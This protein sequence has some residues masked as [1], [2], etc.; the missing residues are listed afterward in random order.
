VLH[1]LNGD[2][3]A[4]TFRQSGLP[5]EQLVWKEA[6]IWGPTPAEPNVSQ[7][8]RLRADFLAGSNGMDAERCFEN[9]MQQESAVATLESHEEVVLW[10][11][12]DLFCQLNLIYVLGKLRSCNLAGT[13]LSLI[14]IGDFPGIEDFRGLG[15]LTAEQLASL[16]PFREPV[17]AEQTD[18]A[19]TAWHACSSSNPRDTELLLSQDTTTLPFL[20][21]ALQLHLRRFPS[22]KNGLGRIEQTA[23]ECI[24]GGAARFPQLF[25]TWSRPQAGYGLGDTQFWDS[26]IRLVQCGRPL[27]RLDG[28]EGLV[29]P[30]NTAAQAEFTLTETGRSVLT[31]KSDLWDM[32][33]QELWLG[34][35][36]LAPP[37]PRWRWDEDRQGLVG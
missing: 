2:S 33:P 8:C 10:F 1:I 30:D 23:L 12:F 35:V 9:L 32:A 28:S 37:N 17:T 6:L 31:G 29:L 4:Q 14:C 11:E 26:L 25:K 24:A 15:Q 3:T 16:F 36:Q 27:L 34:G 7:W 5:G 13:R 22:V 19:Q 18:L 21:S 20:R